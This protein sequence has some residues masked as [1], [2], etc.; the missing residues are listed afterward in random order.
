MGVH[1]DNCICH[2]GDGGGRIGNC[3]GCSKY[4]AYLHRLESKDKTQEVM[5]I[6]FGIATIVAIVVLSIKALL[7]CL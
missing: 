3:E 4:K 1:L 5:T 6:I 7:Y 2:G